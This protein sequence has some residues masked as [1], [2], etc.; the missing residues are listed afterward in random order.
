MDSR[1]FGKIVQR[2]KVA[3]VIEA[4]LV[5][6]VAALHLTVVAGCVEADKLVSDTQL[7]S[8]SLKQRAD[9]ACCWKTS[10]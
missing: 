1:L 7:S 3:A 2:V 10:W 5:F 9:P 6:P 8:G 4:F